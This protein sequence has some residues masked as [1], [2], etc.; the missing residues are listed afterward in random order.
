[1]ICSYFDSYMV[2]RIFSSKTHREAKCIGCSAINAKVI[3]NAAWQKAVEIIR[4][5]SIVDAAIA[6]RRTG[7][8]TANRRKQIN[9]DLASIKAERS[10]LQATLLR[11]IKERTLDRNTEGVLT[12]RLK[13]LERLEYKYNGELLDDS[14]I[15]QQW[16][17]E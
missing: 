10:D 7:D 9:K 6:G 8:P 2:R 12:N 13:E 15:H 5:P 1:M 14:K 16:D 4:N 11:M 3:D 17:A